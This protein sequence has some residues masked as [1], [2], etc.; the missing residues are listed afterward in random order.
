MDL[1]RAGGREYFVHGEDVVR[2]LFVDAVH[3][4]QQQ[5]LAVERVAGVD[6]GLGSLDGEA[7][8]HLQAGRDDPGGDDV[9]HRGT[10]LGHVV[11]RGQ[12][13]LRALGS[14]QQLD[15]DFG[16]HRQ[17]ALGSGHQRQQVVARTVERVAADFKQFAGDGPGAQLEDVVYGETVFQAVHAAR[18]FR[19]VAADR[20]GDL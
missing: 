5:G 20:T 6:E 10:G 3:F 12:H 2:D 17:H 9:A 16:D 13:H 15:R 18:V 8:H 7:V 1:D 11:E 14:R 19:H 4:A